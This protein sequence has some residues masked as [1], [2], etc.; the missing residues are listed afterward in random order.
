[1][2]VI[3]LRGVRAYGRHGANPGERDREQPFHIEVDVEMDLQQAQ[4]S[5]DLN[6]TL[7]YAALHRRI[8]DIVQST[9]FLL[10]ERLCG[11]ILEAIFADARVARAHVQIGKPSL[12]EGAT[13]S[14][15][16]RRENPRYH[17]NR[18]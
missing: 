15:S 17:A 10:L 9:S 8:V 16:L 6:D 3:A 13:P 4:S 18:P 11:E 14:V 7:D 5:D 1:V 12:L 2:D